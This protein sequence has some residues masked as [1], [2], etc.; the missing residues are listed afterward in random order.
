MPSP[1]A[2]TVGWAAPA[3]VI[4]LAGGLIALAGFC[5][6]ERM[7]SS[8]LLPLSIFRSK[9][10]SGTNAV[11][12]VVYG[13]LGGALFLLPID[14]QQVLHYSP[15]AAGLALLPVTVIMLVLSSRSGALAARIGP[16]PQMTV[17]PLLV[18][19]GL[20]LLAR[21]GIGGDYAGDVFP[22]VTVLGLGLAVTVAPLT[23]T[24]LA[25]APFQHS[26][27]AS[28]I[29]NDVARAGALIAVAVLPSL[30]GVTGDSY[31]HPHVLS[32]GFHR[33][34]LIA[35]GAC[36]VGAALSWLT[37]GRHGQEVGPA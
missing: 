33:A 20:A 7:V 8:P 2:P 15:I 11:T 9:E 28:A 30:A 24:V 32:N 5:A 36:V 1:R 31:L 12:L 26:G 10:F 4:S 19:A 23:S 14:L 37:V 35:A 21:V 3:V 22:A 25:A 29:N 27:V 16:R 13:G 17:G 34:V 18:A 6:V